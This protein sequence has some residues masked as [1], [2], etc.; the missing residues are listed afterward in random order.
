MPVG[1]ETTSS[2]MSSREGGNLSGRAGM[3]MRWPGPPYV[4]VR[5]CR[6]IGNTR[7]TQLL[8]MKR[9]APGISPRTPATT[10]TSVPPTH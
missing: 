1:A 6:F 7:H 2:R 10:H 8:D 3:L 9:Q 5:Y 4:N